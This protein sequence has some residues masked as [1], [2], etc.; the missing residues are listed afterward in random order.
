MTK[1][2]LVIVT[3]NRADMLDRAI[4]SG[5]SQQ[6]TPDEV[7]VINNKSTDHTCAILAKYHRQIDSVTLSANLGGAGGFHLGM[8]RALQKGAD[9]VWLMDDDGV[10]APDCLAQLLKASDDHDLDLVGPLVVAENDEIRLSFGL[11][12]ERSGTGPSV[13]TVQDAKK[14]AIGDVIL[15]MA[16]PFNGVLVR[17]SAL[18]ELGLVRAEMFIW[19]DEI[20]F[21]RRMIRGGKR[22][23]TA[24]TALH[25]HPVAKR[26]TQ[27]VAL[28]GDHVF[29]I[30]GRELHYYRNNGYNI[31]K[32]FGPFVSALR[33]AKS[34]I[35]MAL[36]G[37]WAAAA[38]I[39]LWWLDG[40]T[41]AYRM[42][43]SRAQ[44]LRQLHVEYRTLGIPVIDGSDVKFK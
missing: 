40:A 38:R 37:R 19:G 21:V 4:Q 39:P 43:P 2:I 9:W 44:L 16:N 11:I 6:R 23:G 17:A 33:L 20:E 10:P 36:S 24:I 14:L 27:K 35:A 29:P 1:I 8:A 25:R 28:F 22:V 13:M 30:R 26:L 42:K 32:Q 41:D 15:D 31:T 12:S 7:I 5:L 3:F 34:T 18:M